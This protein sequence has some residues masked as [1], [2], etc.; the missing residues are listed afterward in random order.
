MALANS[1][2]KL[3]KPKTTQAVD[4]FNANKEKGITVYAAA[5]KFGISPAAV[6]KR[7]KLLA[8]TADA[9]CPCCGQIVKAQA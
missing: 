9:R 4:Y 6:Y 7:I 5:Q 2:A 8:E 3:A 1:T